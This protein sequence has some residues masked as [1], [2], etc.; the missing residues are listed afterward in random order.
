MNRFA[1][2]GSYLYLMPVILLTCIWVWFKGRERRLEFAIY[3]VVVVGGEGLEEVL[4]LLFHRPGPDGSQ[5]TFPSEQALISLAVYGFSAYLVFRHHGKF[6]FRVV[7]LATVATICI[8][9]GISEIY[10][11]NQ[12]PSDVTAGFIFGGLWIS[13]N[14]VLLEIFRILRF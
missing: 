14:V 4:R 13:L 6:R 5:L 3:V 1:L 11:L 7:A 10:L 8:L 2:F 9:V 12:Y